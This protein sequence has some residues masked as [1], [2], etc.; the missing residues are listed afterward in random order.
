MSKKKSSRKTSFGA[1]LVVERGSWVRIRWRETG[2][3]VERS[4]SSWEEVCTFARQVEARLASGGL[5]TPEG[6]FGGVADAAL[7]RE[8]FANYSDKAYET[9]RS[10]LRI[11]I[12]PSLRSKKA[13]LVSTTDCAAVLRAIFEAGY[14]KHTVGF[15]AGTVVGSLGAG[16][17]V[18]LRAQ[19]ITVAVLLTLTVVF[20]AGRLERVD[21]DHRSGSDSTSHRHLGVIAVM[22]AAAGAGA[23]AL[24][25]APNEWAA[26]LMRDDYGIGAWAGF[27]T[28]AFGSGMLVGRFA[29][30]HVLARLGGTR[31]YSGAIV[32][33]V[34]GFAAA[35][36]GVPWL[37]FVG[38]VVSGLGQAVLFPRLYLL[39]SRVPGLSAASGLGAL[40]VGLSIGGMATTL[41]MG[42]V[43]NAHDVRRALAV[44][45]IVAVLTLLG[46]NSVV[47]RR[48]RPFVDD[49]RVVG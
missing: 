32:L 21:T 12:M 34:S 28:V 41:S 1:V 11:H 15:G 7:R 14:S 25:S 2:K 8:N 46:A 38:L 48:V 20:M 5:G 47:S 23:I 9:R 13:R 27:G 39:A 19:V 22:L 33:V 44:V 18:Y 31:M 36:A 30:D 6:T 4:K 3:S 37:A 40:M 43:S 42:A 16:I 49:H 24:E 35:V 45:G 17:G 29:G 10:I 26:L